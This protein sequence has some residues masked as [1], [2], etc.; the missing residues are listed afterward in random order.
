MP[1]YNVVN[2]GEYVRVQTSENVSVC[3][4]IIIRR[5]QKRYLLLELE[6][7]RKEP[8]TALNLQIDQFNGKGDYLT[9]KNVEVAKISKMR[10][11][12]ILKERIELDRVCTD[13]F[14]KVIMA[15]YG[16]YRF[17]LDENGNYTVYNDQ[18]KEE[19]VE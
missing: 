7:K 5:K 3:K 14:A 16:P 4:F 1:K 15:E 12:F 6:N 9:T 18:R 8:L 2:K 17:C 19:K 10:G 13:F 11:K